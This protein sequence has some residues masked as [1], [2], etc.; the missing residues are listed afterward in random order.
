MR[1][2]AEHP[3][4]AAVEAADHHLRL[5][6]HPC[7]S[8]APDRRMR[9]SLAAG[10]RSRS[11]AIH[12]RDHDVTSA[13]A[14]DVGEHGRTGRAGTH[15]DFDHLLGRGDRWRQRSVR[16][17][18]P[19]RAR[20]GSSPRSRS[21]PQ[22]HR[23]P[24]QPW[25]RATERPWSER[26]SL[27]RRSTRGPTLATRIAMS[28]FMISNPTGASNLTR[29]RA[30]GRSQPYQRYWRRQ[31]SDEHGASHIYGR[32]LKLGI[33][34]CDRHEGAMG[35]CSLRE[36]SRAPRCRA[37]DRSGR[38]A[39]TGPRF[40]GRYR[41]AREAAPSREP[42]PQ[43]T[44]GHPAARRNREI[45]PREGL[46][47]LSSQVRGCLGTGDPRASG[48][49]RA[50]AWLVALLV[51]DVY[52]VGGVHDR[53]VPLVPVHLVVLMPGLAEDL[54]DLPPTGGLTVDAPEL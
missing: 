16:G 50:S 32:R 41:N 3:A 29:A 35:G 36:S 21:T 37:D 5:A 48:A 33:E 52:A 46:S 15:I 9:G 23:A 47:G 44:S 28:S 34:R 40:G 24:Q 39:G 19:R 54:N 42:F 17:D 8:V 4:P 12:A 11:A 38:E 25:P 13:G 22:H 45:R 14:V 49:E 31:S 43:A 2:A 1:C 7:H 6:A 27:R 26:R 30:G 20:I 53:L 51:D 10:S 18:G